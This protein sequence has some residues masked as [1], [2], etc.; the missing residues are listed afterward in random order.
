MPNESSPSQIHIY[1]NYEQNYF[2][3]TITDNGI[4]FNTKKISSHGLGLKNIQNRIKFI[5]ARLSINSSYGGTEI[6]ISI[7]KK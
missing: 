1:V 7:P 5:Q 2:E 6:K 4:G 3:L